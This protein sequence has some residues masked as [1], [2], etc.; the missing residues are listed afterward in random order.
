MDER[1][2]IGRDQGR[3]ASWKPFL[4]SRVKR[5]RFITLLGGAAAAQQLMVFDVNGAADIENAFATMATR[6]AAGQ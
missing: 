4:L 6:A 5:H 3:L 2:N 1:H